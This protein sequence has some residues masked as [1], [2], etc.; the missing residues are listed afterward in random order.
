[1]PQ[2]PFAEPRTFADAFS[3]GTEGRVRVSF[4]YLLTSG[5]RS[6]IMRHTL[7]IVVADQPGELSRI[8][9][10]FSARGFNIE[11]LT[12]GQTLDSKWSRVTIVTRGDERT[13]QH[14]IK[15]C[16]RL[17]R[18][19]EVADVTKLAHIERE[20]ALIDVDAAPGSQRQ[21]V[22]TLVNV[23]RAKVVDISATRII[24]EASGNRDKVE[25]LIELLRPIGIHDV[26][27]SG[28]I[29]VNRLSATAGAEDADITRSPEFDL[30]NR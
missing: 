27:R 3:R 15:Q 18:V 20:M 5:T 28:Y 11:T 6:L 13:I 30:V 12:V 2:E 9:G 17:A 10:L 8:V 21:E 29:A 4:Y 24:I 14:I 23:F 22:L 26:T 16:E 19:R 1:M 7:S 25:A